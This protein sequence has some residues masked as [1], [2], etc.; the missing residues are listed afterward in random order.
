M[1]FSSYKEKYSFHIN[2]VPISNVS[3][4]RVSKQWDTQIP[5]GNPPVLYYLI[6]FRKKHDE[7]IDNEHLDFFSTQK[8][9]VDIINTGYKISYSNGTMV[10]VA[11]E[12]DQQSGAA[13]MEITVRCA[14]RTREKLK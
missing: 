6:T 11:E 1:I 14:A 2:Q 12:L 13:Y 8:Y 3:W 5:D 7:R 9:T 10:S 4:Y